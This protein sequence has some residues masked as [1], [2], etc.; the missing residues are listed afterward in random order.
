MK[1]NICNI[2]TLLAAMFFITTAGAQVSTYER[3][4]GYYTFGLNGGLAYQQAD[5]PTTL[6]G[7]GLGMTL[8]KNLY[9]QP[10]ALFS[11]D[12][13]GRALYSQTKGQDYFRSYG[14]QDN[15]ALNG[16]LNLDYTTEGGGPGFVFQ[17]NKT[18]HAE[19]GLEGVINFNKLREATNVNLSLFGGI[20]LDWYNAKTD[21]SDR[22]GLYSDRYLG[23]DTLGSVSYIK[24]QLKTQILDGKYETAVNETGKLGFMPSLGVEL[25]YQFTP[26]FSM[27]IGHKVTFTKTDLF[28]GHQWENNGNLT[29]DDDIHHYTNLHMRWIIDDNSKKLRAPIVDITNP[30]LS[31]HT[32]RNPTFDI[33]ATVKNVS[34]AMDIQFTVNGYR[35]TFEFKKENLKSIIRLRPG[36]NE[37]VVTATNN[38]GSDSDIVNIFY[39]EPIIDNGPDYVYPTVDITNPP[40]DDYRTDQDLFEVRAQIRNVSN[41]NDVEVTING[42]IINNFDFRN[43][44]LSARADLIEGRNMIRIGVRNN[45][46]FASDETTIILEESVINRPPSVNITTPYT[47]PYVTTTSNVSI[48]ANVYNVEN[49]QD[50]RFTIDGYESYDFTFVNNVFF[51]NINVNNDQTVVVIS[52]FNN[53]GDDSDSVVILWEENEEPV[54]D[55]P[56]V[57]ITSTSQPTADPFDP[58]NCRSTVIATILNVQDR[59][60]IEAF[61]NGQRFTDFDFN[62]NT[63][64]L[65]ATVRLVEGSN[66]IR[67]TATNTA[68]YDEDTAVTEGCNTQTN[69]EKPPIV[70][71]TQPSDNQKFTQP[72]ITIKA[73]VLNIS[74]RSDINFEVNGNQFNSFSYDKFTN[75]VSANITLEKG[76]NTVFIEAQ[77]NDGTASDQINI[78]YQEIQITRPP[79]VTIQQPVNNS[80]VANPQVELI[81]NV[82]N[83][84]T[85]EAIDIYLNGSI[86]NNFSYNNTTKEIR[87]MLTLKNG[88]SSIKVVGTNDAGSDDA[89]VNVKYALPVP[90]APTVDIVKPLN[91]ITLTTSKV[92]LIAEV[93]KVKTKEEILVSVNGISISNFTIIKNEVR[94]TIDLIAGS[95]TILVRATTDG[96][97]A[98][99]QVRVIYDLPTP[100][101]PVVNITSPRDNSTTEIATIQVQATVQYITSKSDITFKIN[102]KQTNAFNYQRGTFTANVKLEAGK[103][104]VIISA[105][106][107]DG[108]AQDQ[109]TVIYNLPAPKVPVVSIT[110]PRDNSTTET[111]TVRVQAIVQN[112]TNRNGITFKVNGKQSNVFNYKV[113]IF[114]AD[115]KLA[116][117]KNTMIITAKNSD[118]EAQ[119]QVIVYYQKPQPRPTV[120]ITS[121][122]NNQT[123]EQATV[124]LTAN[125]TYVD[126][127]RNVSLNVNGKSQGF[128]YSKGRLNAT[129]ALEKGRNTV[130]VVASN[131]TGS[132]EAT[133]SLTHTPK[134][135]VPLPEVGFVNPAKA[136]GTTNTAKFTI[137]AFARNVKD[138]KDITIKM[139]GRPVSKISFN[140]K[141]KQVTATVTLV[142]GNNIFTIEG[143]NEAGKDNQQSTL[144]YQKVVEAK[145]PPKVTIVSVSN[146][147]VDPFDPNK[148]K[149]TVI[150]NLENVKSKKEITFTFNGKTI[151]NY[152]FNSKTGVLQVTLDLKKGANTFEIKAKNKDGEDSANRNIQFGT[153]TG[154]GTGGTS[155]RNDY[156]DNGKPTGT[157]SRNGSSNSSNSSSAANSPNPKKSRGQ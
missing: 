127:E 39:E 17:N 15:D 134:V 140:S 147:T 137:T 114:S 14:I 20:G 109:V 84:E 128:T 90:E 44:S 138:K 52:A 29:G 136:G 40:Y 27:G 19:L 43:G 92:S 24:N 133:I 99:D 154:S 22:A 5:I 60:D 78:I 87:A 25:G 110:A 46:G 131:Q 73:T 95:N 33:R 37:V 108:E 38:A 96:G 125:I 23:I 141:T 153:E 81:A 54:E 93:S 122:R 86:V 152:S 6:E 74:S 64:I 126:S 146:P 135:E 61:L 132:D 62:N 34:S 100:K 69:E 79:K 145:F 21:Q 106:N 55:Q 70:T 103:N 119:D 144:I 66:Q 11:F 97:T 58:T 115:V 65:K 51:A 57:T 31:P 8:A 18:D 113:G 139:N 75:V 68:G 50:I 12:I 157:V 42:R 32:T 105:R 150:A 89:S 59:N 149:S 124:Q 3:T 48:E 121:P 80:I 36:N 91:N 76:N 130:K 47:D 102:G 142:E 104:T 30:A 143:R 107:S 116:A 155:S 117:G 120:N 28:D 10:G 77:N 85:K 111:A 94:A 53:T 67:I 35:E 7:Y 72:E 98:Q 123:F 4:P 1:K 63:Q 13:R 112:I 45:D 2:W 151:S 82:L 71:I 156:K 49:K 129:L 9:Y 56:V 88:N 148:A 16:T 101:V 83:V 41:R 26:R 118:G